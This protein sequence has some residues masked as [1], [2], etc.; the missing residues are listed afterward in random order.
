[1]GGGGMINKNEGTLDR[2]I[3]IMLGIV[4]MAVGFGVMS[5]GGGI[6]LGVIGAMVFFT[7]VTGVCLIYKL[8]NLNTLGKAAR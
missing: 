2:F 6:A 4:M 1:M 5:G 3:R 7:G 8:F